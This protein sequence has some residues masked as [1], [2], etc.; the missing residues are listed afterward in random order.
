MNSALLNSKEKIILSLREIYKKFGYDRYTINKF[1]EYDLYVNNKDFLLSNRVITFT[2]TDGKLL[3]LKPDVTLSIIKNC[4]NLE[5][6]KKYFYDESVYRISSNSD[7]FKEIEQVGLEC[8]GG[9]DDYQVYEVVSLALES[10]NALSK[11]FVLSISNLDIIL[12]V[13]DSVNLSV[14]GKSQVLKALSLKSIPEIKEVCER[15]GLDKNQT[16]LLSDLVRIYGDIKKVKDKLSRFIVNEES[17]VAVEKFVSILTLLEKGKFGKNI[18][19]DFSVVE[20][21]NYYNGIVFNGVIEKVSQKILSGGQYDK[22]MSKMN[23]NKSAIGFAVYVDL[24]ERIN[25]ESAEEKVTVIVYDDKTDIKKVIDK[26]TKLTEKGVNVK[27]Q[28][29]MPTEKIKVIDL[30]GDKT[31]C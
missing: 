30:R 2:D 9:V 13:I 12:A 1:E 20:D 28:K 18:S 3:A 16:S 19:V 31:I 5:E 15:E 27:V 21:I 24:L 14:Q 25:L 10:L 7:T 11:K 22:L 6:T 29:V 8:L 26:S 4:K 23:K 17:K